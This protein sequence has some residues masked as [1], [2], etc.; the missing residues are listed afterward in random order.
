MYRKYPR[1]KIISLRVNSKILQ[2]VQEKI[3]QHTQLNNYWGRNYY[4]YSDPIRHNTYEKFTVADLLEEKL[5]EYLEEKPLVE[6]T[7][8]AEK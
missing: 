7:P 8:S 2:R 4:R 3:N 1:D 6:Q 5:Q